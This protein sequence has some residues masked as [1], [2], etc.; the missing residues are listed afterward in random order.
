MN[1]HHLQQHLRAISIKLDTY[2][3]VNICEK[4][5][6]KLSNSKIQLNSTYLKINTSNA[7]QKYQHL[8]D[9]IHNYSN[10]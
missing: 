1:S 2:K 7:K 3:D 10:L 5:F 9:K 4:M 6:S 8:K